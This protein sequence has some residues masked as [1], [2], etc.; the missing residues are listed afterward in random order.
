MW[1]DAPPS[2]SSFE[3]DFAMTSSTAAEVI[4]VVTALDAALGSRF[5]RGHVSMLFAVAF[6]SAAMWTSRST[7]DSSES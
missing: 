7:L 6:S 4:T 1:A 3:H 5:L 2:I